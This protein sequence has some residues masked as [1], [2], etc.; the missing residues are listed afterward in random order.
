MTGDARDTP[1]ADGVWVSGLRAPGSSATEENP[2]ST[3]EREALQKVRDGDEDAFAA[4]VAANRAD[5][6]DYAQTLVAP[7]KAEALVTYAFNSLLA[8]A[9]AG[10]ELPSPIG[11]FIRKGIR[12]RAVDLFYLSRVSGEAATEAES[13]LASANI[14]TETNERLLGKSFA[15]LSDQSARILWMSHVE[16]LEQAEIA[17]ELG[18]EPSDAPQLL[19]NAQEELQSAYLAEYLSEASEDCEPYAP[20]LAKYLGKQT[21][22]RETRAVKGHLANCTPCADASS[23]LSSLTNTPGAALLGLGGSAILGLGWSVI[24]APPAAVLPVAAA[25]VPAPLGLLRK[26]KKRSAVSVGIGALC[27]VLALL[28]VF[29]NNARSGSSASGQPAVTATGSSPG[30]MAQPSSTAALAS[31]ERPTVIPN[32][33]VATATSQTGIAST[34]PAAATRAKATMAPADASPETNATQDPS[35]PAVVPEQTA[36]QGSPISSPTSEQEPTAQ[37]NPGTP[38]PTTTPEPTVPPE[39]S[40]E[41][42]YIPTPTP[43]PRPTPTPTP[44]PKPTPSPNRHCD[45]DNHTTP[46]VSS[47]N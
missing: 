2:G 27:L 35:V 8:T 36:E 1:T 4:L 5:A 25:T 16:G 11:S 9:R 33:S 24:S 41:P 39:P 45:D 29:I 28:G 23:G 32:A 42:D 13:V 7:A 46:C 18:I 26:S 17:R 19:I 10:D 3:L 38:E 37:P 30:A 34:R 31:K 47:H 6:M 15:T 14:A 22:P 40:L 43:R 21:S 12:S 44:T 20:Q